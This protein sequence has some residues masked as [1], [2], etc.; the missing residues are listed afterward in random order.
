MHKKYKSST[1]FHTFILAVFSFFSGF[2]ASGQSAMGG[3]TLHVPARE[4]SSVVIAGNMVYAA[5]DNGVLA[6]DKVAKEKSVMTVTNS[7]SDVSIS[8]MGYESNTNTVV[9]GY[10]NGNVDLLRNNTVT[11]LPAIKLAQIQGIKEIQSIKSY[12][13]RIYLA[14]GFGVVVVDPIKKEVRET[15]Y[16][17]QLKEVIKDIAFSGD[18]IFVLTENRVLYGNKNNPA[19]GDFNQWSLDTRFP[20]NP[21]K[22]YKNLLR[23]NSDFLIN[24]IDTSYGNDTVYRLTGSGLQAIDVGGFNLQMN[25]ISKHGNNLAV[26][27]AGGIFVMNNDYS[28]VEFTRNSY[29]AGEFPDINYSVLSDG[30]IWVADRFAGLVAIDPNG[31]YEKISFSGPPKSAFYKLDWEAGKLI[32]TGGGLSGTYFTFNNAGFYLLNEQNWSL[33]SKQTVPQW[34][35]TL[36]LFDFISASINP[37]NPNEFALGTYSGVPLTIVNQ[38]KSDVKNFTINNSPLEPTILGNGWSYISDLQ[39]DEQGNLWMINSYCDRTLKVRKPDGSWI[40]M[41]MGIAS[42]NG[43][44]GNMAIDYNNNIWFAVEGK[45][46]F[47][48]NYNET[49]D[50]VAD[51]KKK[52][53]LKGVGV[54]NLPSN[55]VRAIAVDFD[56]EIWVGTDAGFAIIYNS[57]GVFD[58]GPGEYDAQRIKLDFEGNVEYL[59]G[60]TVINDIEIDGGNRKWIGTEGTGI[61]LM[62]PDGLTILA[63]YTTENSP[64]I[65]NIVMDLEIDH[66]TGEV[67]AITDKGLIS[68]RTDASYEDPDYE[69]V[70]VFPNPAGPNFNGWITIQGIRYNSDVKITDMGGKLVYQTTSNGG[71]AI[72]NGKNLDGTKVASGV[73]L[74]WTAANEGKGRKVGKVVVINE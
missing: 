33:Y 31:G 54:G 53:F 3:W 51:D 30:F 66:N 15:Y 42:K 34:A 41:D 63:N 65:S 46:L 35:D 6:Y 40:N 18:T 14:T 2:M 29:A 16:P 44:S 23:I 67:Y 52:Q 48:L 28:A 74:I 60:G 27:V 55:S 72:W 68:F 19:L 1:H 5:F 58:A 11:N 12:L 70:K 45:G 17:T 59:L 47:A 43:F 50:N 25:S 4:A 26:N 13:G 24:R 7:L 64:L 21:E 39:Y 36:A 69:D 56:N 38:D 32:A 73:Y 9:I 61:F 22:N 20:I 57:A 62:S 10:R 8:T 49:L 71:T 37:K